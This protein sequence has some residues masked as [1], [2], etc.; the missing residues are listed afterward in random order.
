LRADLFAGRGVT[1][2]YA[3]PDDEP[4]LRRLAQLDESDVPTGLVLLAE[5]GDEL[6]AAAAADGSPPIADPFR[7]SEAVAGMLLELKRRVAP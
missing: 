3:Y 2:R 6:W 1:I 7:P 4:A 5:V